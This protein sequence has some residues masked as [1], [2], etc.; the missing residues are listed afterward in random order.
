[1]RLVTDTVKAIEEHQP[2]Y[3]VVDGVGVGAGVVDRLLEL[4]LPCQIVDFQGGSSARD[5]TRYA[6]L[7][8]ECWWGM[9]ESFRRGVID[10]EDD[11]RLIAQITSRKYTEKSDRTIA[12]ESKDDIKK[13]GGR[14][15]D[16][17]DALAMT[18]AAAPRQIR[19]CRAREH[20]DEGVAHGDMGCLRIDDF[21]WA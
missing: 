10:I 11:K 17:G 18:Y 3:V 2:D 12:L 14:S 4:N 15:P 8:A 6:N 1:M 13:R 20:R 7:I 21:A 9:A 5:K 16:E 19:P